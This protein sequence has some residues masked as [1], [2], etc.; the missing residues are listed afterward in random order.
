M[1]VIFICLKIILTT[2][3]SVNYTKYSRLY[4]DFDRVYCDSTDRNEPMWL[5]KVRSGNGSPQIM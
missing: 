1:M 3:I 2:Q 5:F 4:N